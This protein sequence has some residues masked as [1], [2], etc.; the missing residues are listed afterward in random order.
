MA[1]GWL[2]SCGVWVGLMFAR[3]ALRRMGWETLTVLRSQGYA[4]AINQVSRTA[5][6]APPSLHA[7]TASC[8]T[9]LRL[10]NHTG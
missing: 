10:K 2:K 8:W 6:I 1:T 4:V 7:I 9:R 5:V 3:A